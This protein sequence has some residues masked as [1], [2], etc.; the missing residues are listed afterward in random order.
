[1][2]VSLLQRGVVRVGCALAALMP[3]YW[4]FGLVLV[5]IGLSAQTFTATAKQTVAVLTDRADHAR[6]R[7]GDLLHDSHG[8]HTNRCPDHGLRG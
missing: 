4:L 5:I 2:P 8:R 1:M 3:N 7:H 6:A